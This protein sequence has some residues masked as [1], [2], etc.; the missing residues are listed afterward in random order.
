[1]RCNLKNKAALS[2]KPKEICRYI[3]S[4]WDLPQKNQKP[5]NQK[6]SSGLKITQT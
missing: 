6:K 4:T 5:T 1:M 2:I 3:T